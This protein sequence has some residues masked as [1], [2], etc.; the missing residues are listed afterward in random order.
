MDVIPSVG[1][2]GIR[3]PQNIDLVP[4]FFIAF[5]FLYVRRRLS[6][7]FAPR[8]GREFGIKTPDSQTNSDFYHEREVNSTMKRF[9]ETFVDMIFHSFLC[10]LAH[11]LITNKPWHENLDR[12]FEGHP[13]HSVD[14][15]LL[16]VFNVYLGYFISELIFFLHKERRADYMIYLIHHI[17]AILLCYSCWMSNFIR[18]T[19]FLM[20]RFEFS[21]ISLLFSKCARYLRMT[22]VVKLGFTVFSV[23]W[24][25]NRIYWFGRMSYMFYFDL[26]PSVPEKSLTLIMVGITTFILLVLFLIWTYFIIK[27]VIHFLTKGRMIDLREENP[28]NDG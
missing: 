11:F 19:A 5:I 14:L 26:L 22:K 28:E 8:I 23:T 17:V 13:H 20:Y 18:V 15:S 16:V 25:Y 1:I 6:E 27:H 3:Y 4:S 21:D 10:I 24:I 7:N 12:I 2:K 9:V